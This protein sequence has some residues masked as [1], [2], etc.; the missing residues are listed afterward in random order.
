MNRIISAAIE[1]GGIGKT[2]NHVEHRR[3]AATILFPFDTS[4]PTAFIKRLPAKWFGNY[5]GYKKMDEK[6]GTLIR[7]WIAL[8]NKM[9]LHSTPN[10]KK[11]K[12]HRANGWKTEQR[13]MKQTGQYSFIKGLKNKR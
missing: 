11:S 4:I 12:A 3:G 1:Q 2:T 9:T 13:Y 10:T 8:L 6:I 7:P 5:K